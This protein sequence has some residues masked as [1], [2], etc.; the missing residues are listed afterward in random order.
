MSK[1][2][3]EQPEST[4]TEDIISPSTPGKKRQ[5]SYCKSWETEFPFLSK[6]K[7]GEH[8]ARCKLCETDFSIAHG[9]KNDIDG[10]GKHITTNKHKLAAASD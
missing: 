5:V 4:T 2:P 7:K 6:S 8:Y 10:K 1:R 9:G 3:S